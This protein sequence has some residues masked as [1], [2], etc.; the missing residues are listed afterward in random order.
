M[1][2][3]A[4]PLADTAVLGI[5]FAECGT[6]D[7]HTRSGVSS[8]LFPSYL[9][10]SNVGRLEPGSNTWNYTLYNCPWDA[11]CGIL[12]R[13]RVREIRAKYDYLFSKNPVIS[14]CFLVHPTPFPGWR[15]CYITQSSSI[16]KV[17]MYWMAVLDTS[18]YVLRFD[19]W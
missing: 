14:V 2:N 12:L 13:H 15:G 19:L 18:A 5:V 9:H 16:I 1:D 3:V 11:N 6:S 4:Q 7:S 10:G 17:L 8:S